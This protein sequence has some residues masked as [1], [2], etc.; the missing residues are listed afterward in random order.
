MIHSVIFDM[1]GVLVDSN[2]G[3]FEAFKRVGDSLGVPFSRE[4]LTRTFGMH[5]NQIFP[6]WLGG[7]LSQENISEL[8]LQKESIY[9]EIV[10]STLTAIPGAVNLVAELH[11]VGIP[12]AVGSSGPRANV[13]LAVNTLRLAPYFSALITGDDVV[14]GKPAP[15]V[16]LKAAAQ[17]NMDPKNCLVI[18]DAPQGVEAALAAGMKVIAITT[19]KP[20]E[21]LRAAH[22]IIDSFAEL[23]AATLC[24]LPFNIRK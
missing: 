21:A 4:M 7:E 5:N 18:E 13:E 15:D 10:G 20:R 12:L 16:F 19:S 14:H 17:L 3:H 6:L 22:L 9:R 1:D 11:A 24:H 8:A 23:N 2:A